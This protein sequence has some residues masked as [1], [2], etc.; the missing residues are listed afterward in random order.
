MGDVVSDGDRV[1][2]LDRQ[3]P[4]GSTVFDVFADWRRPLTGIDLVGRTGNW[5]FWPRRMARLTQPRDE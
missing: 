2:V 4:H 1:V 3:W 5:S